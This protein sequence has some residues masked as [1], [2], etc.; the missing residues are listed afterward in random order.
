MYFP[1]HQTWSFVQHN[2][3]NTEI[4]T[5]NTILSSN[6]KNRNMIQVARIKKKTSIQDL[7]REVCIEPSLLSSFERGDDVLSKETLEQICK[8]LNITNIDNT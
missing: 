2:N 6:D 8:V 1:V 4:T 3:K 5:K 7:A